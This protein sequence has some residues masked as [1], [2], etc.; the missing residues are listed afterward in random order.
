MVVRTDEYIQRLGEMAALPPDLSPLQLGTRGDWKGRG[1]RLLG[2]LRL[3][4]EGGSWNEWYAEFS[5]GANGW[6]AEAQGFFMLTTLREAAKLPATPEALRAKSTPPL[7]FDHPYSV[8]DVKRVTVIAAEGELPEV[9]KPGS[10]RINADLSAP[11]GR[12]GTLEFH[13]EGPELYLGEYATFEALKLQELRRV[14]GWDAEVEIRRQGSQAL[15]CPQCGAVV[16]LRA[17]GQTQAAVCGSC[18][19]LLDTANP[20]LRILQKGEAKVKEFQPLIPLGTR[21]ELFGV[22]WEAIGL[23]RRGNRETSWQEYLLFNPWHG[24]RFLT[25]WGGH[26]NFVERVLDVPT[27]TP[28]GRV[29]QK[30]TYALFARGEVEVKAVLGEFYWKVKR[31]EAAK[32]TDYVHPPQMLSQEYYP[33]LQEEAF[34]LGTYVEPRVI[35]QA[36]KVLKMPRKEGVFA[37]Q[38]NPWGVRFRSLLPWFI[39]A[40][41]VVFSIQVGFAARETQQLWSTTADYVRPPAQAWAGTGLNLERRATTPPVPAAGE[42]LAPPDPNTITSPR[43]KIT[44]QTTVPVKVEIRAPVSNSWIGFELDLVNVETKVVY[45]GQVEVSF[46]SGSDSDGAWTEGSIVNSADLSTLR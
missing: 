14:P 34:S 33:A 20:T 27:A 36:F 2:R 18:A 30:Q 44:G 8:V 6:V 43:F 3:E 11:G 46:Y 39:L 13:P 4:Y 15:N 25:T 5:D 12:C 40:V 24:F 42:T 21:G 37:N 19:T 31:G 17:V 38:P 9:S 32:F 35:Q 16:E 1:F 28:K 41:I 7:F 22:S 45:P 29:L 10:S 26:W 23:Q